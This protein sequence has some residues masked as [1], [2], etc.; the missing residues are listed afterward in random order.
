MPINLDKPLFYLPITKDWLEQY[1]LL[2]NKSGES[3]RDIKS[4][5]KTLTDVKRS[6]GWVHDV[7]DKNVIKAQVFNKTEDLS[8]I[9][10]T[11]NDEL[12]DHNRPILSAI[13]TVS[14]YS[15]LMLKVSQR[16][17]ETWAIAL[18][19]LADKGYAP[20]SVILDGLLSLH[21][22]HELGLEDVRIIYDIFHMLQ[23]LMKLRRCTGNRVKSAKSNLAEIQA[24]LKKAR[25]G[26]KSVN[27]TKQ[28]SVAKRNVTQALS[29]HE[30]VTT[31]CS[32]MQHDILVVPGVRYQD[33]LDLLLFVSEEFQ[34][35]E[36]KLPNKIKPIRKSLQKNAEKLLGFVKNLEDELEMYASEIG[37]DVYWLWEICRL[38]RYSKTCASYYQKAVK[39]H[40]RFGNRFRDIENNVIAIMNDIEKASSVVENLNGRIRKFLRNHI[41]V[42]Q[43]QLDLLRFIMN[44]TPFERSRCEHRHR[45]SPSEVLHGKD[46]KHWL[47][48]LGYK[49]FKLVA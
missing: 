43:G 31:L 20:H 10:V 36:A 17:A 15:P 24:R 8:P 42:S 12:Y 23:A 45:K 5:L 35:I 1:V 32:W 39:A 28:Q 9:V 41:H 38:Q 37:C 34:N 18:W 40:S 30:T 21:A 13:C 29:L 26:K 25:I 27:Y 16:D 33:R 6:I 22:G 3:Y 11:A 7:I 2:H 44:H 48:M 4:N 46:H 49:I 47:E 14:L 19:E